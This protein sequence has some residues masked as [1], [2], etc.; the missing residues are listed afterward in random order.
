MATGV[1]SANRSSRR[2]IA[3]AAVVLAAAGLIAAVIVI[4]RDSA[5]AADKAAAT[6][7]VRSFIVATRGRDFETACRL[8]SPRSLPA[9]AGAATCPRSLR[10]AVNGKPWRATYGGRWPDPERFFVESHSWKGRHFI[11]VSQDRPGVHEV[12]RVLMFEVVRD[13]HAWKVLRLGLA[14]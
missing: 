2:A 1:G 8:L 9:K 3:V 10:R 11:D 6:K 7:V 5:A 4:S 14:F 13:D 12:T